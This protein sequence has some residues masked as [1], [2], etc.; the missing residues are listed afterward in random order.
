L[1]NKTNP[2]ANPKERKEREMK[3]ECKHCEYLTAGIVQSDGLWVL[4]LLLAIK[5]NW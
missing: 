4:P 2:V 5:T 1:I 3:D